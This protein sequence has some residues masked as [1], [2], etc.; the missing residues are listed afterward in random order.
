M[1]NSILHLCL[2]TAL[3]LVFSAETFAVDFNVNLT[4]DEHD[5]NTADGVCDINL[6]VAGDQCSLRAVVEQANALA[7]SDRIFSGRNVTLTVANGGEIVIE[8][9]GVLNISFAGNGTNF[10]IDGGAGDNR[11]FYFNGATVNMSNVNLTGG[12]GQGRQASNGGAIHIEGGSLRLGNANVMNNSVGVNNAG[13]G[14]WFRNGTHRIINSNISNNSSSN[15]GGGIYSLIATLAVSNTTISGNTASS[16]GGGF[17]ID[18]G[19]VTLRNTTVTNNSAD[20]HGGGSDLRQDAAVNP[21][22]SIVAGNIGF[23]PEFSSRIINYTIS[24]NFANGGT[25]FSPSENYGAGLY[26]APGNRLEIVNSTIFGNS[27]SNGSVNRGGGIYSD[28]GGTMNLINDI[29]SGNNA[30]SG[31]DVDGT[32]TTSTTNLI[33]VDARLAPLGFYGGSNYTHALLSGSPAVNAGSSVAGT[34]QIDQRSAT[35]NPPQIKIDLRF[36]VNRVV[37]RFS[38]G[39]NHNFHISGTLDRRHNG[40]ERHI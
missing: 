7:S 26:R 27:A 24:G 15:N 33:G 3:L 30:A 31:V 20:F 38:R 28:G 4:T 9:N 5:A 35:R 39:A 37:S 8:N 13:G 36:V 11:I 40:G 16:S 1:K 6:T 17:Y 18:R 21:G 2:L 22:N 12:N 19:T 32:V 14:I 10:T 25:V 34:P 23:L 29:V